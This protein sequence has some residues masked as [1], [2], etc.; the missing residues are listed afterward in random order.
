M[1][2]LDTLERARRISYEKKN[3]ICFVFYIF[4]ISHNDSMR[5]FGLPYQLCLEMMRKVEF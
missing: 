3:K 2:K 4:N 5:V 1:H